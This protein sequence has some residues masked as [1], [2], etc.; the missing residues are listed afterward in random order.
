MEVSN[1]LEKLSVHIPFDDHYNAIFNQLNDHQVDF[2]EVE[3][4]NNMVTSNTFQKF[5]KPFNF[6]I[7]FKILFVLNSLIP[8]V[9]WKL[10][11]KKIDEIEFVDTFRFG[12]G[13]SLFPIFYV[14]Q[15][16]IVNNFYGSKYAVLYLGITLIIAL[17]T[18]KLSSTPAE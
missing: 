13:I 15:T 6:G 18:S 12:I 16:L 17:L 2:T 8:W 3:A 10:I 1:Q 9:L 4:V 5:R 11:A 7:L 14:I